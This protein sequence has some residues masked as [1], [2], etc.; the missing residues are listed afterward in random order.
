MTEN[1][2]MYSQNKQY[3]VEDLLGLSVSDQIDTE[4]YDGFVLVTTFCC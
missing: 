1:E 4:I 3:S 2:T